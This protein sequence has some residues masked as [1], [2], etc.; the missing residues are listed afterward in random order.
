M[1]VSDAVEKKIM[2]FLINERDPENDDE[3]ARSHE[4]SGFQGKVVR[5]KFLPSDSG[6]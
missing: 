6:D 4:I 5:M 2:I 1:F 3:S